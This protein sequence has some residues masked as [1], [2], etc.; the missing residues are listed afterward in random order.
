[1]GYE[2]ATIVTFNG[3][4]KKPDLR[5]NDRVRGQATEDVWRPIWARIERHIPNAINVEG[6]FSMPY[7]LNDRFR[8]YRCTSG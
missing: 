6:T 8:F 4:V 2:E 7:G 3:I 5:N 1:M